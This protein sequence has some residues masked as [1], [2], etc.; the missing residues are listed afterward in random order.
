V[1]GKNRGVTEKTEKNRGVYT[2]YSVKKQRGLKVKYCRMNLMNL[3][4]VIDYVD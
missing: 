3:M 1:T 2:F 4:N